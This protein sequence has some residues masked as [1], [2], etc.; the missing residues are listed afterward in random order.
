MRI[1]LLGEQK[2]KPILLDKILTGCAKCGKV[3]S[4]KVL[5]IDG[6][7]FF[8]KE[9]CN[10]RLFVDNDPDFFRRSVLENRISDD[11]IKQGDSI[12]KLVK[13][14][15]I[16]GLEAYLYINNTCNLNCPICYLK[17]SE[18][19]S[20]LKNLSKEEIFE[21]VENN[22]AKL[23]NLFGVEP[24]LRSDLFELVRFLGKKRRVSIIVTNGIKLSDLSFVKKLRESGLWIV[25]LSFDGFED[26]VYSTL[27]GRKL[28][29]KKM[30]ALKNLKTTRQMTSFI[31]VIKKDTNEDQIFPLIK[32]AIKNNDFLKRIVFIAHRGSDGIEN[33]SQSDIYKR[34]ADVAQIDVEYFVQM[35]KLR[36]NTFRVVEKFFGNK[37]ANNRFSFLKFITHFFR[38]EDEQIKPYFSVSELKR[39]NEILEEVQ[40]VGKIR[41]LIKLIS[42]FPVFAKASKLMISCRLAIFLNS[43]VLLDR[44]SRN[45]LQMTVN[46]VY[47]WMDMIDFKPLFADI[48]HTA[49]TNNANNNSNEKNP[50][51]PLHP[52]VNALIP[53]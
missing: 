34:I 6:N 50:M 31:S 46:A 24:S 23:I 38:I 13:R 20:F 44:V 39:A 18:K 41:A 19:S 35:N 10:E 36:A 4:T 45:I 16:T 49:K 47:N 32:F 43:R 5:E 33:I 52:L 2:I 22:R 3:T 40:K 29:L 25:G 12:D 8:E 48:P 1:E 51:N 14:T 9:C 21:I 42:S 7:V 30:L 26:Y 27:R 53:A 37:F 15:R 11:F 28:L 17:N